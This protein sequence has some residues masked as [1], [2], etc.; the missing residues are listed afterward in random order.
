MTA[1]FVTDELIATVRRYLLP[2][3]SDCNIEQALDEVFSRLGDPVFVHLNML[4]GGIAKPTPGQMGHLYRGDEAVQLV[5]EVRR[6]NAEAFHDAEVADARTPP[7]HWLGDDRYGRWPRSAA[8]WDWANDQADGSALDASI[9]RL[10]FNS[11]LADPRAPNQLTLALRLDIIRVLGQ[12]IWRTAQSESR[13]E[14]IRRLKAAKPRDERQEQVATWCA[15]AFGADHA[16]SPEQRGVRALEEMI[17]LYQSVDGKRD[18]AHR[19]VD[20]IVDRPAG[21]PFQELGGVGVTVLALAS[22]CGIAADEAEAAEVARVLAKPIEHFA[23]RNQVKNDAGFNV[24]SGD[25]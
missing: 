19:L 23:A 1:K 5:A 20:Y 24:T 13:A 21:T 6:Q 14:V 15:A 7:E 9:R 17:E 25:A 11:D 2:A 18:M 12:L 10:Q 8:G 4:R 3:E 22:A 16:S